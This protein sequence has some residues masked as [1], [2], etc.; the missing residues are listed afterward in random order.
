MLLIVDICCVGCWFVVNVQTILISK[1]CVA[2]MQ[3]FFMSK[4]KDSYQLPTEKSTVER[5]STV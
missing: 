5:I 4:V 3:C 2:L 1:Y